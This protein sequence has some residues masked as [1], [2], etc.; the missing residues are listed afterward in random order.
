MDVLK[1]L[2]IECQSIDSAV[3]YLHSAVNQYKQEITQA[4]TSNLPPH[5]KTDIELEVS[6]ICTDHTVWS[7]ARIIELTSI[8]CIDCITAQR[9]TIPNGYINI[10]SATYKLLAFDVSSTRI[11]IAQLSNK[12]HAYHNDPILHNKLKNEIITIIDLTITDNIQLAQVLNSAHVDVID[13]VDLCVEWSLSLFCTPLFPQPLFLIALCSV[14]YSD[15]TLC[16]IGLLHGLLRTVVKRRVCA[17]SPADDMYS[18]LCHI[19]KDIKSS[20]VSVICDTA[21]QLQSN[22]MERKRYD[23]LKQRK[24]YYKSISQR[25]GVI[26]FQC[27]VGDPLSSCHQPDTIQSSADNHTQKR[28]IYNNNNSIQ[29]QH[30]T[31]A[32]NAN[33]SDPII[34]THVTT[35][36][37][38]SNA[39]HCRQQSFNHNLDSKLK[40]QL[41]AANKQIQLLQQQLQGQSTIHSASVSPGAT[42][43]LVHH[44]RRLSS[45]Q[46]SS[47][48]PD[49]TDADARIK[50]LAQAASNAQSHERR[51][52]GKMQPLSHI[53]KFTEL[54]DYQVFPCVYMEGYLTKARGVPKDEKLGLFGKRSDGMSIIHHNN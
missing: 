45:Q 16:I 52:S 21:Y 5:L 20:D 50:Y 41:D 36:S 12:L 17:L 3:K 54:L 49:S 34:S 46:Q 37:P 14:L 15:D 27:S 28:L 40:Q 31:R 8:I 35:V 32:L 9:D 24:D 51:N 29:Q 2:Y 7:A 38:L 22:N 53:I 43:A 4:D 11:I 47:T 13:L 30:S 6:S 19:P 1:K 18:A 48:K 26:S 39:R 42:P 44:N 10:I 33:T 25:S 23:M